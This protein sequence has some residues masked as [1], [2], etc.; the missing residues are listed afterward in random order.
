MRVNGG[1]DGEFGP[2]RHHEVQVLPQ[3]AS[4]YVKVEEAV[5]A[6]PSLCDYFR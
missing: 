2:I 3:C 4:F 1:K 6:D 5:T